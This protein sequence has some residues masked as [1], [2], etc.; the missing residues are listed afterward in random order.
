VQGGQHGIVDKEFA[1]I[2]D[3]ALG[4]DSFERRALSVRGPMHGPLPSQ[5]T[6]CRVTQLGQ[7]L[8]GF[9]IV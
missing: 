5:E 8:V 6:G 3:E 1:A 4:R 2:I 7:A 9:P